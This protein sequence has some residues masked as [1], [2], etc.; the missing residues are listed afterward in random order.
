M[1]AIEWWSG[2]PKQI[3][4]EWRSSAAWR[5]EDDVVRYIVAPRPVTYQ[6]HAWGNEGVARARER[7]KE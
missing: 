5:M 6:R 1:V 3:E 7:L 4:G 2:K